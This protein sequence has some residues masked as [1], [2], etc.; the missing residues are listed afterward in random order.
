MVK[1]QISQP[2]F[3]C[4]ADGVFCLSDLDTVVDKFEMA[5]PDV[6]DGLII[7]SIASFEW[8]VSHATQLPE[9]D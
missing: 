5:L 7:K 8:S 3:E 4:K 1:R 6:I 2:Y 9:P